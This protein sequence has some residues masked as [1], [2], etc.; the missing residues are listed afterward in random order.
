MKAV[1][2]IADLTMIT[3]LLRQDR[4]AVEA[5]QE[6]Y[7]R[8][9]SLRPLEVNPAVR[10]MQQVTVRKWREFLD[11]NSSHNGT[12]RESQVTLNGASAPDGEQT[13][14]QEALHADNAS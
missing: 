3:P 14:Q 9:W 2:K 7:N 13:D 8:Y 5:E 11:S 6:G 10:E 1:L 4:V 12:T